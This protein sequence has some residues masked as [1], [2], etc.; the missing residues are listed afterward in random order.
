MKKC[1]VSV[2]I[3]NLISNLVIIFVSARSSQIEKLSSFAIAFR[4]ALAVLKCSFNVMELVVAFGI[5]GC[6]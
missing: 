3:L 6:V 2:T 1:A 5:F 4:Y